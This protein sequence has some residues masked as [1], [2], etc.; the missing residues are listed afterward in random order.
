MRKDSNCD[1]LANSD[2]STSSYVFPS[3][4]KANKRQNLLQILKLYFHCIKCSKLSFV[5]SRILSND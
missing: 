1:F 2:S 3:L 5:N 4:Y